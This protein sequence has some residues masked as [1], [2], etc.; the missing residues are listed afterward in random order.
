MDRRS[1]RF[2]LTAWLAAASLM[3]TG[4]WPQ[5]PSARA[6]DP[7]TSGGDPPARVGRLARL[8]GEV[9]THGAGATQWTPAVLNFPFVAGDALWTQPQAQADIEIGESLFT[10]ADETELDLTTLDAQS[11]VAAE[12]QG[13]IFVDLRHV[14]PGQT[15][16]IDTPRGAVQIATDGEYEILAGDT[17]TPTRVAVVRGAAQLTSGN[18]ALRAHAG[19]M[20]VATG[21]RDGQG[22]IEPL[23]SYDRFLTTMLARNSVPVQ[24]PQVAQGMT[25]AEGLSQYGSWQSN[26]DYG[27]IWYPQ[28]SPDWVPYREGSWSYIEPWGWTWVDDEPWGFAPFH[29]G[30]WTQVDQRWGWIPGEPGEPIEATPAYSPALVDFLVAGAAV[31]VTA[32]VLASSLGSGRGD[33]GWVPLGPRERYTP[34]FRCSDRYRQRLNP[35][36]GWRQ[37]EWGEGVDHRAGFHNRGGMTIAPALAVARSR[38]IRGVGAG[39]GSARGDAFRNAS[40]VRPLRGALPIRPTAE[41]RGVTPPAARR[42]GINAELAHPRAPGPAINPALHGGR[43][44]LRGG[45]QA[46]QRQTVRP[47]P[48]PALS[49][50]ARPRPGHTP[51]AAIMPPIA[52]RAAPVEPRVFRPAPQH[53]PP[54][55]L[56]Q[57]RARPPEVLRPPM[58]PRPPEVLRPPMTPRPPMAFRPPMVQQPMQQP[59]MVPMRPIAPPPRAALPPPA[60][61]GAPPR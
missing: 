12:P 41:T 30:R 46:A 36:H 42:L 21:A 17:S 1:S 2:R 27:E 18:L 56:R 52:P 22:D 9:S 43:I 37:P 57:F 48:G 58:T 20:A 6:Q 23:S 3:A 7:G 51:G 19:Q 5:A 16:T 38:Q 55:Q 59:R 50:G 54:A 10:L 13:A 8:S 49:P 31:G 33:I 32:A 47:A 11:L 24:A 61:A 60:R 29:Y 53:L 40:M 26:P 45:G 39:I 35:G 14:Q 28:V 4:A 15:Y 34:P 44:P 25:G